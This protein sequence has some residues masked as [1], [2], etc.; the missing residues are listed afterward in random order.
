MLQRG[1]SITTVEIYVRTLRAIINLAK[2]RGTV[3]RNDYPFGRRKYVIP[4]SR[5]I[6]KA[7]NIEQ[8]KQIFNYPSK[9]Y[10]TCDKSKKFLDF[11]LFM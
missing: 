6:K 10:S 11:Q 8:I 7:L 3:K 2:S 4:S 5:N 1:K 9:P